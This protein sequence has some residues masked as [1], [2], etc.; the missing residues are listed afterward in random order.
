[1]LLKLSLYQNAQL[2]MNQFINVRHKSKLIQKHI[3][4]R[5]L[6]RIVQHSF[7]ITVSNSHGIFVHP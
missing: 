3:E 5:I 6:S 1:M 4:D 2:I 7:S